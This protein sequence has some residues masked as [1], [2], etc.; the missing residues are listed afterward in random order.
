[1]SLKGKLFIDGLDAYLEYG[2]FVAQ[3]GYK[4]LIQ[5]PSFKSIEATSWP[6]ED[7]SEYDLTE[8]QLDTRTLQIEFNI[9][10]IDFAEDLFEKLVSESYH[11]FYFPELKKTYR[12]RLTT[13]GNLSHL[14]RLGKISLSFADDFPAIPKADY[15]PEGITEVTQRD[16][17]LDE[18]DFSRFG[19][20]VLQGTEDNIRKA[21][22]IK[23]NL[24]I[25]VKNENGVDYDG[26]RAYYSSKDVTLNLF[27]KAKN[28]DEFWRRYDS[29]FALLLQPENRVLF[30]DDLIEEYEC[31]YKS[32]TVN[33]FDIINHG[34]IWCE[35]SVTL[36]FITDKHEGGMVL[37]T[38]N[39]ICITIEDYPEEF[40]NDYILL[41][42]NRFKSQ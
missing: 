24:K 37:A 33:K 11:D 22:N 35:F 32:N 38:E 25:S 41:G 13:N 31:F 20:W 8:P 14:I 2:V 42:Q 27:I 17:E 40:A 1:M 15:Y 10:N 19:I 18:V 36:T 28:I 5:Y 7:G 9:L 26:K 39:D 6:E 3:Y 29:L 21:S 30:Y 23:E 4:Q 12:L 34:K 16:F